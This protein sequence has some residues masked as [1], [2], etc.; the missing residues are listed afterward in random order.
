MVPADSAWNS[1]SIWGGL[2]RDLTANL[3]EDAEFPNGDVHHGT[4]HA[5]AEIL[6]SHLK[7]HRDVSQRRFRNSRACVERKHSL[8]DCFVSLA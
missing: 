2:H 7:W 1:L 4:V 6:S 8:N 3:H 5:R